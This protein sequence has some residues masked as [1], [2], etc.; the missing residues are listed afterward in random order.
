[1]E[2]INKQT[3]NSIITQIADLKEFFNYKFEENKEEHSRIEKAQKHTNGDVRALKLWKA[4]IIGGV[5][6]LTVFSGFLINQLLVAKSSYEEE[7]KLLLQMDSR[8]GMVEQY[9]NNQE[10]K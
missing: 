4:G 10:I 1:M 3:C 7:T 5:S 8:I 6:V 2:E 9:V